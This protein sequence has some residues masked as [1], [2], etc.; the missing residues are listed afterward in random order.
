MIS[1]S[2]GADGVAE[3][4]LDH[5]P[6]NALPAEGWFALAR[7]LAELGADPAVRVV[8]LRAEEIGRAHV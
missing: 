3:C 1:M 4:V 8:V 6:V 7:Q 5:P 2:S